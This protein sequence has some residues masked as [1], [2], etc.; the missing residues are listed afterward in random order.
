MLH[1]NISMYHFKSSNFFFYV[2]SGNKTAIV[3]NTTVEIVVPDDVISLVYGENGTNLTRLRQV[4]S[5]LQV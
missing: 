3:T 5:M 2:G 1:A 4:K